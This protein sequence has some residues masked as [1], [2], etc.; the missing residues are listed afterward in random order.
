MIVLVGESASGKSTLQKDFIKRHPEYSKLVTYTTR[1][2]RPGEVDGVDYHFVT[3]EQ[4]EELRAKKSFLECSTYNNWKYGTPIIE[5]FDEHKIAILTP[6]GLR[7]L[8]FKDIDVTAVYL[9]VDR[10]SRLIRALQ[11]GDDIEEAYRRNLSDVG[12]FDAIRKEV[13]YV[14][15][16]EDYHMDRDMVMYC[17][18]NIV[19]GFGTRNDLCE[20]AP[21]QSTSS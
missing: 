15:D 6:A 3:D 5:S 1:A 16:N 8:R 4:F 17:L 18:E 11:R 20:I 21:V 14:I 13:N 7:A 12:A 9:S 10:R 19:F 2:I